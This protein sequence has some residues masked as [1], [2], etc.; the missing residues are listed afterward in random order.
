MIA[1]LRFT[2]ALLRPHWPQGLLILGGLLFEVGYNAGV[3]LSF[4]I[5]VDQALIPRN[6]HVLWIILGCL[7]GA[8]MLFFAV[9]IARDYLYANLYT[10][11]LNEIRH[12]LFAHL[13]EQSIDFHGRTPLGEITSRFATDLAAVEQALTAMAST[14]L[15]PVL[16]LSC[17]ISLL[18]LL[19]WRLALLVLLA[20]PAAMIGPRLLQGRAQAEGYAKKQHEARAISAVQDTFQAPALMKAFGLERHLLG[21]FTRELEGLARSSVRVGLLGAALER[22]S[23]TGVLLAHAV[24]TGVG[25]YMVFNETLSLGTFMAFQALFLTISRALERAVHYVPTLVHAASGF[26]RIAQVLDV[27]P[28]VSDLP[29]APP[30]PPL[31][32]AIAFEDVT[33][34]YG[35][36]HAAI[37]GVSF[38]IRVGESVAIVGPSGSGKSTAVN[39]LGRFHDP[40]TGRV[41]VDGRDLRAVSQA[42]WRAQIGWVSQDSLFLNTT[43]G[44]NIRLGKVDA[45]ASEVAAAAGLA[46]L[47]SLVLSFPEG[48][49]AMVGERGGR[50]SGGQRQRVALARALLRDPRLLVLDEVTSA[51]DPETE[52]AINRT[53]AHASQGR[54]V[55]MVTHRLATVTHADRILV[56]DAGRLVEQGRHAALLAQGGVYARLWQRQHGFVVST[57]GGRASVQAT[58]LRAIPM[59]ANLADA[60]LQ[61]IARRFV[62][63]R[64][65]AE[66]TLFEE[67]DPGDKFYLI[68]RGR[69]EITTA[70]ATGERRELAW[71]EDGDYFGEIA[72]LRH[73]PR[74]A[75]ARTRTASLFL[76]LAG[77][78]FRDMMDAVPELRQAFQQEVEARLA[79]RSRVK[80]G[81]APGDEALTD[82]S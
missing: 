65:P 56:F 25:A 55:V 69:V 14:A 80:A 71:R 21:S 72:L 50:L 27:E 81:V 47:Q 17:S 33:F 73:V 29:D 23:V 30:L 49:A 32:E 57:G 24:A 63:E 75:T 61:E 2:L 62:T 53:L 35:N 68:V 11:L 34:R 31:R 4:K 42:S 10:K 82:P 43:L 19:E 45:T 15:L 41:L 38:A 6:R 5:L 58:R 3:S 37:E 52:A 70:G 22:S 77:E 51:L 39:L 16:N 60:P 26:Q 67:G 44:E 20:L 66:R 12:R 79:D 46:E 8:V 78:Q 1:F 9:G 74:T 76:T 36:G 28:Q 54:T 48:Y 18:F 7:T 40:T 64:V 59:F 13:Q